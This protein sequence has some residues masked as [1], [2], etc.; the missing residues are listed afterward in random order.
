MEKLYEEKRR[1]K[2][3]KAKKRWVTVALV[4]TSG[5]MFYSA[6]LGPSVRADQEAPTSEALQTNDQ[7]PPA[8]A[9]T[10]ADPE[11]TQTA[12][13]LP[14]TQKD[15]EKG[16]VQ[17]AWDQGF[18]G[19]GTVVSVIDSGFDTEHKDFSQAPSTPK[20]DQATATQKAAELGYGSYAS[21]KFPYVYNYAS[22]SNDYIKDNGP[23]A[24]E[25]GQHVAG[26]IGANGN[27]TA[28]TEYATGVA[29]ESQLLGLRVFNDQFADENRDDIAQAIYDSVKLGADVIQMSL[30]QGVVS[31]NEN[32]VEQK[33]VQ[34]AIEHGVFVSI[35]A[36][37]SGHAGSVKGSDL[38]YRP[39]GASGNFEPF[40]SSTIADPGASRH[41]L[42]VAAET[43]A[44]GENSQM[45]SFSSWGPLP[46]FT[47]KPDVSAP[48]VDIV[49][50][51]NDN[52][53]KT[54][55]GTSM[56]GPFAA[57]AAALVT[58]RLKQETSLK[59]AALVQ[60]TKALLMNTATPMVD[61]KYGSLVSP[62]RQGAGQI[63]VGAATSSPVYITTPDETSSLSLRQVGP[64]TTFTLTF[65][66]LSSSD[67]TYTFD[68]LGGG[69]TEKRDPV[70]GRYYDTYLAGAH[71]YGPKEVTIKANSSLK[72]D[73]TLNLTG[74]TQNQLVEGWLN[75]TSQN[76]PALVIPYLAYFGDM[77]QE[78][79]FDKAA[80]DPTNVYGGNYFVNEQ[81]YPRGVADV[82]SLKKLVNLDGDYDWQQVAKLYESGKVAFS[83]NNDQ[84][85]DLL[86]PYVFVKQNLKELKVKVLDQNGKV[87]QIIADEKGLDKSTYQSGHNNDVTLSL[88]MRNDPET[89]KWDGKIYDQTSGTYV[90]A[91]DGTYTY[92]Y[93][94]TLYNE[95]PNQVQTADYPV[96]ID[97]KPPLLENMNVDLATQTLSFTY[98]D[99]GAGFTDWSYAVV[100]IN[101]HSFGHKLN[102]GASVF[103]DEAKTTGTAHFTLSPAE[104]AYFSNA[105]NLVSVSLSDTADNTTTQS[106]VLAPVATAQTPL[107]VWNATP[108][109][110]FSKNSPDYQPATQTYILKG[111]AQADFYYQGA[112]VQVNDGVYAVPVSVN[113]TTIVF[114]KDQ[115]GKEVLLSLPTTTPKAVF[116][117]QKAQT[118]KQ[119]FGIQLDTVVANDPTKVTVYAAVTKGQNV[120]AFAKDYFNDTVYE[121]TVKDGLATF[122]I[123]VPS[124]R[125]RTVLTGWTEIS[126][127]TFNLAQKTD[128]T[129]VY[130]G[131]ATDPSYPAQTQ[132][133][134]DVSELLTSVTDELADPAT[135]G[136]PGPLPGH[137]LSD[138]TTR[139]EP[140]SEITFSNLKDNDYNWLGAQA[141]N[142][143]LYDPHSETFT[144]TGKVSDQ[145]SELIFLG[146]SPSEN[147]PKNKAYLDPN[148]NFSFSFKIK[149]TASRPLAYIYTTKDGQ[150]T[151]GTLQLIL[152]TVLPEL[153]FDNVS[154][155]TLV[156]DTYQVYT[157]EPR[158]TLTGTANDNLDGYRFFFNG[159]NEFRQFHTF[160]VE[161]GAHPYAPYQFQRS[162]TLN[163][164]GFVAGS[165]ETL[166]VYTLE[167]Q[168]VT[169]NIT[170]R[171]FYVHYRPKRPEPE[172][173]ILTPE[174]ASKEVTKEPIIALEKYDEVTKTWHP[175]ELTS[176]FAPGTYRLVDLYQETVKVFQVKDPA[177]GQT[178]PLV[179]GED[180]KQPA[181]STGQTDHTDQAQP[182]VS[183]EAKKQPAT[184]T[185][186][187]DHTD[188]AQPLVKDEGKQRS[189]TATVQTDHTDQAHTLTEVTDAKTALPQ[190]GETSSKL[191]LLG[192]LTVLTTGLLGFGKTLFK[193]SRQR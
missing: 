71:V 114:T 184:S 174:Q 86:R 102:E 61:Q 29:P 168:D 44:L 67:Q 91:P 69:L 156:G 172:T 50:T 83:P 149:P 76:A 166:H 60:A 49:S 171:K 188:Q 120:R 37:N 173:E 10:T 59:N 175:L 74:L 46:D 136:T 70:T 98:R 93:E 17:A 150:K 19:E 176:T 85:S 40:S 73:Y 65:H 36:S 126:G 110:G 108:G 87:V 124:G 182:L 96:I 177:Q 121:A 16:N 14:T 84:Q 3:Y 128:P 18:H 33:A 135:L 104:L 119:N 181:T 133:F 157:N 170:T 185:G 155:Y 146:D 89:L 1:Y 132:P 103:T 23:N 48:G 129:G 66:N 32:D 161:H 165:D 6:A 130:L 82:E 107:T 139:S 38:P 97:T 160:G 116:E 122:T 189:T 43:S 13:A 58:Q 137:A 101:G 95:G 90:T 180:K 191:S 5:L 31:A 53:Y 63:N 158:F 47:L 52:G 143:G 41:A 92:R 134:T 118:R 193:K 72:V 106:L 15:H 164:D 187:T 68:D 94:A 27:A 178:Q 24:S 144:V 125:T 138:L 151:R 30:G 34:Y 4:T 148:G 42:T 11:T 21:E 141:I 105:K 123:S 39:G 28:E 22:R 142:L 117:W 54:M 100:T 35:S 57:G 154:T 81:N 88:S 115:A 9:Q 131:V 26:I 80:N 183:D 167:V 78:A 56:A 77:T 109:L 179:N 186:Q 20:I 55:S 75:F 111:S 51:G 152:D 190:T 113:E 45:A 12:E 163:E 127:P 64:Q 112:L 79:V 25:H 159:D 8:T 153:N 169:G 99:N 147:D 7:A 2:L 140:N 145:V 62:R 162:F 192:L